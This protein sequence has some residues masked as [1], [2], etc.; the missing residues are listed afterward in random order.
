MC[1]N[2]SQAKLASSREA[3][4]SFSIGGILI[5][6]AVIALCHFC[7]LHGPRILFCTQPFHCSNHTPDDIQ[8]GVIPTPSSCGITQ[9]RVSTSP[10]NDEPVNESDIEA[11]TVKQSKRP[12]SKQSTCEACRSLEPDSPGF[13]SIDKESHISY[14]S[15][16]YPEE[17]ELF[18]KVRHA[19][20]R[21]LSCEVCPGRE[22]PIMFG[23]EASGFVFSITFY[24]KDLQ[25]RGFQRWYSI[26]CVMMDR[27]YLA[28]SWQFLITN[29][30]KIIV[31][32]QAKAEGVYKAEQAEKPQ[33]GTVLQPRNAFLTPGQFRRA[34]GGQFYRS[35]TEII[36]DEGIFENLHKSFS[37]ILKASGLRYTEKILEGPPTVDSLSLYDRDGTEPSEKKIDIT[38]SVFESITHIYSVI[39]D[40][41]FNL[42]AYHVVRGDQLIVRGGDQATVESMLKWLKSLIP[43]RCVR[44]NWYESKYY[45]S[46]LCNFLGISD[47]VV[48][49]TY[50]LD[51]ELFVLIKINKIKTGD[52]PRRST[53]S[54]CENS[55]ENYQF[56]VIGSKFENE[57]IYLTHIMEALR[58]ET[59]NCK[60]FET[61]L[62]ASKEQ[63]MGKVKVIFKFKTG[64]KATEEKDK[65]LKILQAKPEDEI[66]LK[67]WMT[68]LSTSY[69]SHLSEV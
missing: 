4:E 53:F 61:M 26:I 63:W 60:I 32:V 47:E 66:L 45:D 6:N 68:S 54:S 13:I 69:R 51:S 36:Q 11:D 25:S 7:E 62:T 27:I 14:I 33:R 40:E 41:N 22:G 19:C 37:W 46:W 67:Y 43:P 2:W 31:E 20:V 49:P 30:K 29:F 12:K 21:S 48:L 23:D 10:S 24:L 39:G 28:N 38:C 57:P 35:L 3:P 59:I 58:N 8:S 5:M 17:Q 16:Q 52:N 64:P 18:S 42:I 15:M 50:I 55:F 9:S 34:R 56:E 44:I 65:L 1:V